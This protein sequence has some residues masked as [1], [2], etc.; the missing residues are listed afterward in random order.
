MTKK[1]HPS[2]M[3]NEELE[4]L[5]AQAEGEFLWERSRPLTKNERAR[6][7]ELKRKRGRP[8][9]GQGAKAISITVERGLLTQVDELAARLSLSRAELVSRGLVLQLRAYQSTAAPV[10]ARKRTAEKRAG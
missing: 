1:K 6:W 8:M 10:R 3:T 9:K 7:K 5:A 4:K 2:R